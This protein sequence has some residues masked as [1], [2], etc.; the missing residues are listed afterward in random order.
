MPNDFIEISPFVRNA[1][2]LKI[3]A[4]I[5]CAIIAAGSKVDVYP[6]LGEK[7]VRVAY[8][9]AETL[10]KVHEAETGMPL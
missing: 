6:D 10:L 3:A 2:H 1:H 9:L 4:D 5:L 8:T 7:Q